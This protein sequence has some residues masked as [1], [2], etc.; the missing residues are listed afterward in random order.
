MEM[1]LV[2]A[3][4]GKLVSV[5]QRTNFLFMMVFFS[6]VQLGV[7]KCSL[8]E[9]II[10]EAHGGGLV[11]HL[12]RDKTLFMVQENFYWP[13]LLVKRCVAC[14]KAKMH[15]SNAGLYAPLPIPIAPWE[16]VRMDFIMG[17]PRTQRVTYLI[18]V[19]VDKFSKTAHFVLCNKTWNATDVA[20]LYF[21]EIV[22]LHG[23]PKTIT[24]YPDSKKFSH[25]WRTLWKKLGT[26]FQFSL[27]HHPQ[28]DGQTEV[29]NISLGALIGSL[30]KRNVREWK[31][32]LPHAEFAFN[33]STNQ[34]TGCSPF[35]AVYGMNLIA[36]WIYLPSILTIILVVKLKKESSSLSK[37]TS[38]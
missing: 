32:L 30:V 18:M 34:T 23:I 29:V 37:F 7:P 11:R 13:K 10:Q 17:L 1:I 26:K 2:L 3:I 28:T 9:V 25:F 31:S 15:G 20:D 38:K 5:D 36:L 22:K 19:V 33:R 27:S 6:R 12:G 24:S 4:F 16:D 35:E 21:K 14:R 8:K